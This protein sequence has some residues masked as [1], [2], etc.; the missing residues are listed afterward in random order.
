MPAYENYKKI[1]SQILLRLEQ[2]LSKTLYYHSLHHTLDILRH[3]ERIAME[4]KVYDKEDLFLLKVACLYHDS[5]FLL[6]YKG[7]EDVACK[8]VKKELPGFKLSQEQIDIICKLIIATKIPQ[9]PKTRLEQIICDAD[10][11]YLGRSDFFEI[12]NKLFLELKER[13]FVAGETEWN[14]IQINFFK[15]HRYFTLTNKALRAPVKQSHLEMI[16]T[17]V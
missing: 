8:L 17:L 2:G 11:D 16:E 1:K 4:E 3:A 14:I 5:G 6:T 15:Q 10:L 7:H 12:S 13:G 9:N